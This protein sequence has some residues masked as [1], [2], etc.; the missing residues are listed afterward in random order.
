[1]ADYVNGAVEWAKAA[2]WAEIGACTWAWTFYV[3]GW[4]A[5]VSVSTHLLPLLYSW[6]VCAHVRALVCGGGSAVA[7]SRARALWAPWLRKDRAARVV[8]L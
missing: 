5:V 2:D 1:M 7:T 8:G 6:C 4:C 3:L